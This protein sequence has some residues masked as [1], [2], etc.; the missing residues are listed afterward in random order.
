MS[1]RRA[2][3][4]LLVLT[5]HATHAPEDSFFALVRAVARHVEQVPEPF[6]VLI[7][8]RA[9]EANACFFRDPGSAA[10]VVCVRATGSSTLSSEDVAGSDVWVELGRVAAV[11]VRMDRPVTDAFL[12]ALG[13]R[14]DG[15]PVVNS[16][17]G[18][19]RCGSKR[20]LTEM[21]HLVP[22][23]RLVT[24]VDEALDQAGAG[25]IVLKP[26]TGYGGRGIVRLDPD[27]S[28]SDGHAQV[29]GRDAVDGLRAAFEENG[30]E[31]IAMS[32]MRNIGQGDKRVLIVDG[33]PVGAVLRLPGRDSWICNLAHGGRAVPAEVEAGDREIAAEVGP[34]LVREG[35]VIAGIDTLVG[36]EGSRVLSEINCVNVG[37]FVQADRSRPEG[38]PRTV[39]LAARAIVEAWRIADRSRPG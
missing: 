20:L 21:P 9:V 14:F 8:S 38:S 17:E 34:L 6:E 18:M 19:V 26:L 32:Y 11:L 22:G 2:S 5:D 12:H 35:I 39:D 28:L 25:A 1:E 13:E 29:R 37:G 4:P 3:V 16:P 27:G 33:A 7:A 31:M 23:V 10:R 36:N 15:R 24:G 30:G